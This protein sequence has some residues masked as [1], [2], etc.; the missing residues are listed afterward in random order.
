MKKYHEG[1]D[2]GSKEVDKQVADCIVLYIEVHR[3][4][5]CLKLMSCY[6]L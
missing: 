5:V 2:G 1:E 6:L 4:Q 3:I